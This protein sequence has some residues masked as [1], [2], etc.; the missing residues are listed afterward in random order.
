[1]DLVDPLLAIQYI[2][3]YNKILFKHDHKLKH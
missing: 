2:I 1:M 3:H